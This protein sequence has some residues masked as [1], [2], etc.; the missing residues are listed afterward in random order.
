[1]Q[2]AKNRCEWV[3]MGSVWVSWGEGSMG[4]TKTMNVQTKMIVHVLIWGYVRGNF[5]EHHIFQ[6]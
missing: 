5:P 4:D 1:M 2:T 6:K 3:G